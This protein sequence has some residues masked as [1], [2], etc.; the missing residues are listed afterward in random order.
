MGVIQ[1]AGCGLIVLKEL[2]LSDEADHL[3]VERPSQPAG[4]H[5]LHKCYI[6][7]DANHDQSEDAGIH[8][9]S[10]IDNFAHEMTKRPFKIIEH[11]NGPEGQTGHQ[12]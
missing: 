12:D 1:N 6:A 11:V 8:L 4:L 5:G 9:N 3:G 7:I 2:H 10:H